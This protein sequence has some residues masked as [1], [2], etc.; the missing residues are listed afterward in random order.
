[1]GRYERRSS[2]SELVRVRLPQGGTMAGRPRE[3]QRLGRTHVPAAVFREYLQGLAA[4]SF[5]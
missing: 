3:V 1:M 5:T 4:S 2:L